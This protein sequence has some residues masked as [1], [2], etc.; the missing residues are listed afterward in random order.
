MKYLSRAPTC[1]AILGTVW[2]IGISPL[3]AQTAVPAAA[4]PVTFAFEEIVTLAPKEVIGASPIGL[5]Q[6][7]PITGG[8]F[9]G[10]GLSGK[11]MAGGADWQLRRADGSLVV[12]AD[13]MIV[14]DDGVQIH[15][16]NVGVITPGKNDAPTYKWAAPVF[17]AP[18]GKYGWLNDAI[19]VST[20]GPAGDA[21]HPAVKITIYKIG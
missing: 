5:R 21:T 7:V 19:F 11:V 4:V 2:L 13:Y 15:V 6:R 20:L 1:G 3:S 16:H 10:P 8:T 12:D 17:E 9:A 18:M 14:T